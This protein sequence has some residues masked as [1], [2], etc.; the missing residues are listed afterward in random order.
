MKH[1]PV[2]FFNL[3]HG[4]TQESITEILKTKQF[5]FIPRSDHWLGNGVYF[6]VDD[7]DK[8]IWWSRMT[9]RRF[10]KMPEDIGILFIE[11]YRIHREKLLDLD[12]EQD[13]EKFAKFL[14]DNNQAFKM[15]L[16][17]KDQNDQKIEARANLINLIVDYYEM[18]AVKYTF[19]KE[20]IKKLS[21]FDCL[22][23]SNNEVQF[24]ISDTDT[25][26]FD[27]VKDIT[28]EVI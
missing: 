11:G 3:Y 15:N 25:I 19:H 20:H 6:F 13:I 12:S 26:N 1:N 21:F 8:A 14:K 23:L 9:I 18:S 4:T 27:K 24:C 16:V 7:I 2:S 28:Q 17:S 10:K 5:N 22:E